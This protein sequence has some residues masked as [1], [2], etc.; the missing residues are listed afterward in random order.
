MKESM[1]INT[2]DLH[3]ALGAFFICFGASLPPELKQRIRDLTYQLAHHMEHGGEPNVAKLAR[4]LANSL[5]AEIP[6]PPIH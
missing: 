1:E 4:G 6:K 5:T 2:H 3:K